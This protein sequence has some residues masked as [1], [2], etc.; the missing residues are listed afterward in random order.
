MNEQGVREQGLFE[1]RLKNREGSLEVAVN[2][3][4]LRNIG[5]SFGILL[6]LGASVVFLLLSTNRARRLAQQQIEFVAGISHELRTP[7]AVLKSAGEN[8]ADGVIQEKERTRKY[9]ELIKSEVLRLSGMVEKALAYAGIQSGKQNYELR[10]LDVAPIIMEALQNIKKFLPII[11]CYRRDTYRWK[12]A[13]G[14][15]QCDG[16]AI[17]NREPS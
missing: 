3:N 16:I 8:L 13:A 5:I 15:W 7:L 6:L 17:S 11:P 1:L 2:N 12:S 9:G 10:P 4:R 14:T